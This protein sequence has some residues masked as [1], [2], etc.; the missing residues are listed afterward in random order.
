MDF[1]TCFGQSDR[2]KGIWLANVGGYVRATVGCP[3]RG[4]SLGRAWDHWNPCRVD[5]P[6]PPVRDLQSWC[7]TLVEYHLLSAVP[8]ASLATTRKHP[9]NQSAD[10]RD[11]RG[12][13]LQ[14][15]DAFATSAGT[16]AA[17]QPSKASTGKLI[18]PPRLER[19][20][21]CSLEVRRGFSAS[22]PAVLP[23]TSP[24]GLSRAVLCRS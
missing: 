11:S 12:P 22:S 15:A 24:T 14:L 23:V 20:F 19:H 18:A 9:P 8:R 5:E 2:N 6:F 7:T 16:Q 1:H 17:W 3:G 10:V 21:A 4:T 13:H